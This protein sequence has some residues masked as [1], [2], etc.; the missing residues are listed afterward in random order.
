MSIRNSQFR[1]LHVAALIAALA[2]VFFVASGATLWHS[3]ASGSETACPI[4]HVAH[5]PALQAAPVGLDTAPAQ[6]TW[7][8]PAET[9]S[10][11]AEP[12]SLIPPPR[13]PPV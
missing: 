11:H 10:G 5:M 4:C 13:A 7:V 12:Y 2:A 3:D 6:I 8:A 9:L 1:W